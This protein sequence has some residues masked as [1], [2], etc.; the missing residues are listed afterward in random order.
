MDLPSRM[1]VK[2]IYIKYIIKFSGAGLTPH[3]PHQARGF[4]Q[5]SLPSAFRLRGGACAEVGG[6]DVW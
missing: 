6:H 1:Y 2:Y 5:Y 3:H 4:P